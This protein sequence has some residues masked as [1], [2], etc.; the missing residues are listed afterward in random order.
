MSTIQEA[1][2]SSWKLLQEGRFAPAAQVYRELIRANPSVTEAWYLLGAIAQLEGKLAESL[3]FYQQR[4][5]DKDIDRRSTDGGPASQHRADPGE[6]L[7]PNVLAG[8]EQSRQQPCVGVKAGDIRP[9]V[10]VVIQAGQRQ[11]FGDG[12]S[13][14]LLG[15]DVVDLEG[16]N[17][18]RLRESTVFAGVFGAVPDQTFQCLVHRLRRQGKR[19]RPKR[20][21]PWRGSG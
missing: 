15:N 6:M 3:G 5:H 11:V 20:S 12:R 14:V 16:Q 4:V 8:V 19:A 13:L 10:E 7:L 9:L 18:E 21:E 17:I 2:A 1:L